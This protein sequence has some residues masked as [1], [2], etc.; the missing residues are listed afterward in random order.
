MTAKQVAV[1][2]KGKTMRITT[3]LLN[4][5]LKYLWRAHRLRCIEKRDATILA[6]G[7]LLEHVEAL[8]RTL[9][10]FRVVLSRAMEKVQ[11]LAYAETLD[12]HAVAD[13]ISDLVTLADA[14]WQEFRKR[15]ELIQSI[16][17]L[18]HL[19]AERRNCVNWR[20]EL[21]TILKF[22]GCVLCVACVLPLILRFVHG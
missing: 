13:V 11:L 9:S 5:I 4:A 10:E 21:R 19:H 8:P 7:I 14:G 16:L 17:P 2:T 12:H 18:F 22:G 3:S 6:F 15:E 20:G 1:T